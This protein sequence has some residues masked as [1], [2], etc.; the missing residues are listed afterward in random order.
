MKYSFLQEFLKRDSTT[1][2]SYLIL[3]NH[4]AD[5]KYFNTS[6]YGENCSLI[7]S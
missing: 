1:V 7:I 2:F 4:S 3:T 5:I 6:N